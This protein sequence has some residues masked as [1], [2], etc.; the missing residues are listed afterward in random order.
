MCRPF[1]DRREVLSLP[2]FLPKC[3]P[4]SHDE[5]LFFIERY[6]LMGRGIGYVDACLLAAATLP[7]A[8][9]WTRDKRLGAIAEDL[10]CT[11]AVPRA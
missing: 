2:F 4:A 5:V 7:S 6:R 11:Y 10:G 8:Q 1:Q 9:V 3:E